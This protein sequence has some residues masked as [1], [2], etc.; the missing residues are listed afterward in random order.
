MTA[1][2]LPLYPDP[3]PEQALKGL[4]LRQR[5]FELGSADKPF[6]YA[7]F[8]SS[9]DGR[10]ALI[11]AGSGESYLPDGLSDGNDFRLFQELHAQADCL[12]THTGY[13]RA[14]RL[15]RL[16][17]ILQVEAG[18][19]LLEWRLDNGLSIQPAVVVASASLNFTVPDSIAA[20]GQTLYVATGQAAD[21]ARAR[22]LQAQ[23]CKVI[24]AGADQAVEGAPL[25]DAL[26]R[27]GY[28]CLYLIAGPRMLET[29]LRARRLARL[30]LTISHRLLGGERFHSMIA[31]APLGTTGGLALRNMYY[32]R[33]ASDGF[34][35]WFAQFDPAYR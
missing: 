16:G 12:I 8:V 9:L 35:Q 5:L 34:G 22:A 13:L 2:I 20:H 25:V 30:Y 6:V 14:L 29:M 3:G 10:I 23:G 32:D 19:D 18:G 21:P 28:R 11:D 33:G 26:G 1:K 4:Y 31:G 27:L 24:F 15:G 7:N 17:N